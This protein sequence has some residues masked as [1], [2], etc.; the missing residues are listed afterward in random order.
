MAVP[1]EPLL[2]PGDPPPV[3]IVRARAGTRL[4]LACEH[5]GRAVPARLGDLGIVAAE[6]DRHIAWDIGAADLA[7]GL[8]R[9]L[10]ATLVLQRYSRLVIDCNRPLAAPD[11][12]PPVSDGTI[13]P[14]NL[15]LDEVGR[16]AR[17]EAIHR[18]F[19][20]ALAALLDAT[21]EPVLVTVH[22]FTP[23]LAG[24]ARPWHAGFLCNRD[25]ALARALLEAAA[26]LAPDHCLALNEP[27]TVD[28]LSDYT[29]PVHGERRG[30]PHVLVEVRNDLIADEAGQEA[31]ADLLA[32]ALTA[33]LE[34]LPAWT[35]TRS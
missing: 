12:A 32:V 24:R 25:P 34:G 27:Y 33:A 19:H 10:G 15:D 7:R 31:W 2:L 17:W 8:A 16:R 5:A 29:I 18:P 9:R 6:M 28:D 3:E 1:V 22:S 30:I 23:R 4:V 35:S 11:L 13:V 14:A 21:V 26:A 20:D